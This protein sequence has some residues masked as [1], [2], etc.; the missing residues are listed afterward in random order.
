MYKRKTQIINF[1]N[2]KIVDESKSTTNFKWK[3]FLK[4]LITTAFSK[5]LF[6]LYESFLI[7]KFSKIKQDF[8]LISK[9]LQK[10][11]FF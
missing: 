8:R 6:D 5:Q 9:C 2:I 3:K 7:S 4:L 10:E 11:V 1:V